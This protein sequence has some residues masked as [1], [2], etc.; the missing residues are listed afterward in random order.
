MA[1][2]TERRKCIVEGCDRSARSLGVRN[3]KRKYSTRCTK[4]RKTR[5]EN[6]VLPGEQQNG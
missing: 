2:A 1:G 4:H 5:T 6:S 3:G